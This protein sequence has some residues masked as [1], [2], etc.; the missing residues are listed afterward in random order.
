[1]IEEADLYLEASDK[2]RH[3]TK[4]EEVPL[5][6]QKY[7]KSRHKIFSFYND[8]V[9]MTDDAW[10]GVTPEPI[11]Y[12]IAMDMPYPKSIER[13]VVI[14]IFAGAGGNSIQFALSGRWHHVIGIERDRDTLVCAKNNAQIAGVPDNAITWILGDC[15]DIL[16][17]LKNGEPLVRHELDDDGYNIHDD[18]EMSDESTFVLDP[19]S[20]VVFASP[21]WGGIA[22]NEAAVFDLSTM[23]PYTL[24][25][26][27]NLCYPLAH[28]LYLPRTSDLQQLADIY[29]AMKKKSSREQSERAGNA[30][31]PPAVDEATYEK[32]EVKQYCM[33][34]F[35]KALVAYYPAV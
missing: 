27:H 5:H 32:L 12:Q 2:A 31:P 10:F 33:N 28:A 9:Q 26:L 21:P 14:D 11:A 30:T 25:D 7:W 13:P 20:T 19:E 22:Y 15:F 4:L 1:M 29:T 17:R 6:I 34:G 24:E 23:E 8:G 3:Y 16:A 18:A 35:S